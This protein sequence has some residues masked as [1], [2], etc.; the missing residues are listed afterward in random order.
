MYL[1]SKDLEYIYFKARFLRTSQLH[2]LDQ[3][4]S[5]ISSDSRHQKIHQIIENILIQR[6]EKSVRQERLNVINNLEKSFLISNPMG[7]LSANIIG[8]ITKLLLPKK[9]IQTN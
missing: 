4:W 5:N 6:G 9:V 1:S 3:Y 7:R 2:T 8:L